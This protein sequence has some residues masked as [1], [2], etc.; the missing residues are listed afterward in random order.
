MLEKFHI[1]QIPHR[2]SNN[3]HDKHIFPWHRM[4]ARIKKTYYIAYYSN[5][6]CIITYNYL[7]NNLFYHLCL[8]AIHIGFA[9]SNLQFC[10]SCFFLFFALSFSITMMIILDIVMIIWKQRWITSGIDSID[11]LNESWNTNWNRRFCRITLIANWPLFARTRHCI[12]DNMVF[13]LHRNIHLTFLAHLIH[14]SWRHFE[15]KV[16]RP[17]KK[18]KT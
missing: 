4:L 8:N 2:L 5:T 12:N 13:M 16:V 11:I 1:T 3:K 7:L 14:H 17:G 9:I 15:E 6:I 10:D 18:K